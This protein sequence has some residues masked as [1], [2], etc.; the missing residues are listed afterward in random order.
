MGGHRFGVGLGSAFAAA[1]PRVQFPAPRRKTLFGETLRSRRTG[2]RMLPD[3]S[4]LPSVRET[5]AR[6]PALPRFA[7]NALSFD[8]FRHPWL[9]WLPMVKK[10]LHTRYRVTDLEKTVHF[11]KQ[12]LGLE[13]VTRSTS[14][15]GSQLVFFKAPESEELIEICKYIAAVRSRSAGLDAFG[16]R[17]G[18]H[19]S[20]CPALCRAWLSAKRWSP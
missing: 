19:G 18:G 10:L 11:Y 8:T 17:G 5:L 12:V 14:G 15:R 6:A 1:N 4:A 2:R 20:F 3:A 13:E 16:F 9:D 7:H